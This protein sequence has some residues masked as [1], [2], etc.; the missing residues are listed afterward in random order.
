MTEIPLEQHIAPSGE[1]MTVR[2]LASCPPPELWHDWIEYD[3][4]AWPRKVEAH[5]VYQNWLALTRPQIHRPDGL[6]CPLWMIRPYRPASSAF[7][8]A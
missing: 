2:D 5:M 6:R 3:A 4:K 1:Q 7:K 8:R